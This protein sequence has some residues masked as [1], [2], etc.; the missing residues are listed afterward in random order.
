L[1]IEKPALSSV[2]II[3]GCHFVQIQMLI[4]IGSRAVLVVQLS[5]RLQSMSTFTYI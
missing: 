4:R 1:A 3:F 2:A 5:Y